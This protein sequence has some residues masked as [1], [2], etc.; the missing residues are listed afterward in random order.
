MRGGRILFSKD[1]GISS[2]QRAITQSKKAQVQEVRGHAAE[3]QKQI[4]SYSWRINHPK[5]LKS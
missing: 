2:P 1:D 3:D 4:Q 5:V